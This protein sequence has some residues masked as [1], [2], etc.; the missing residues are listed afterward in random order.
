[1]KRIALAVLLFAACSKS[2]D[3][4]APTCAEVTDHM[5]KIVQVAY[6]GHGDMGARGNRESQI[7]ACEQRN[8]SASERRCILAAKTT[9]AIA[10]CRRESMKGSAK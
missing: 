8:P 6:P 9:E 5:L 4:K 3:D 2:S 1:M 7:A 10:Q